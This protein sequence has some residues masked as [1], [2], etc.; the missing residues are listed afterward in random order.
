MIL[1]DMMTNLRLFLPLK[2]KKRVSSTG[3][4]FSSFI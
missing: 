1:K 2:E 4:T 3:D